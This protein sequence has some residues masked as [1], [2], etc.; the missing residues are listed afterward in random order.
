MKRFAFGLGLAAAAASTAILLSTAVASAGAPNVVG[1]KYSDANSALSSAK[2]TAVIGSKFGH[3]VSQG[4]CVVT[5]QRTESVPQSGNHSTSGTK[6]VLALNC[7]PQEA[8]A[9]KAGYSAGS[10]EGRAAAAAASAS[11]AASATPTAAAG[12]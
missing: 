11:A 3:G 6:V 9:T 7:D 10:P 12:G 4:D 8:S 5:F 1:Q 2:F